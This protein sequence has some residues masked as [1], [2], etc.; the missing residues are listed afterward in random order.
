[1]IDLRDDMDTALKLFGL[2][3]LI[4]EQMISAPKHVDAL[5]ES[6]P[7]EKRK[8]IEDRDKRK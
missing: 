4:A 3:N 2:V 8:G 6:L 7:E 5:Y 1:M